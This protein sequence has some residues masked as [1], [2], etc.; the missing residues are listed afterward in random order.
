MCECA[1]S[2]HAVPTSPAMTAPLQTQICHFSLRVGLLGRGPTSCLV[3]TRSHSGRVSVELPDGG[4]HE[5]RQPHDK[6]ENP[7][8]LEVAAD[9]WVMHEFVDP[10]QGREPRQAGVGVREVADGNER[11]AGETTHHQD[12]R[13]DLR[14]VSEGSRSPINSPRAEN[15]SDPIHTQT[16]VMTYG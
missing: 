13:D 2:S 7:D 12:E 3:R 10:V 6:V 4:E 5:C 8:P 14:D 16:P 15:K 9:K 11:A 1:S